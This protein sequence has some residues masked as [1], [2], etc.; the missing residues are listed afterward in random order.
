MVEGKQD[1]EQ[2]LQN[3][4]QDKNQIDQGLILLYKIQTG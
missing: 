2:T 3:H 1:G 4:T